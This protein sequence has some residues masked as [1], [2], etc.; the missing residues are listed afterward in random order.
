MKEVNRKN[1]ATYLFMGVVIA[2]LGILLIAVGGWD[3]LNFATGILNYVGG[4]IL[5]LS[6]LILIWIDARLTVARDE[7]VLE[8]K[9]SYLG[10]FRLNG[11]LFEAYERGTDNGAREFRLL[12]TPSISAA[13][14]AAFIRYMVHEALIEV[15]WPKM[16]RQIEEETH[17]AFLP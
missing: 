11:Y 1:S 14:E 7:P 16:S 17:W 2:D 3:A 10:K 6:A 4:S 13:Q 12:S 15:M 9:G 5:F 8:S